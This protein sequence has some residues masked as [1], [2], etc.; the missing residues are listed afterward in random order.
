MG[1]QTF[2]HGVGRPPSA[3]TGKAAALSLRRIRL[4]TQRE[5]CAA[6][7]AWRAAV[8]VVSRNAHEGGTLREGALVLPGNGRGGPVPASLLR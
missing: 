3:R 5:L 8:F 1:L 7:M 4:E 6:E 2:Q